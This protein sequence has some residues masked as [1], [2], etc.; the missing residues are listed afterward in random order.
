MVAEPHTSRMPSMSLSQVPLLKGIRAVVFDAVG[1]LIAPNPP[2]E[3]VYAGLGKSY[4]SKLDPATIGVRSAKRFA[5]RN[6]ILHLTGPNK[7]ETCGILS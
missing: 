7:G 5:R 4:G 1:T 3:E 6:A 2:V